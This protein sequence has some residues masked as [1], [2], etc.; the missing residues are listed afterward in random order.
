LHSPQK[1]TDVLEQK[2]GDGFYGQGLKDRDRSGKGG[3]KYKQGKQGQ[4]GRSRLA[5]M[6]S[7]VSWGQL[8]PGT[9]MDATGR[10]MG[11]PNA[12]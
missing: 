12:R 11:G 10:G 6:A 5:R 2:Q 8:H 9:A 7:G 4:R 1:G 3:K